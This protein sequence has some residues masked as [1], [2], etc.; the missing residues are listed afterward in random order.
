MPL[1]RRLVQLMQASAVKL[2]P[3]VEALSF[4]RL[5]SHPLVL[6]AHLQQMLVVRVVVSL[7]FAV[8][9]LVVVNAGKAMSLLGPQ[10][11]VHAPLQVQASVG[12]SKRV[13][14]EGCVARALVLPAGSRP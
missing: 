6:P 7:P 11:E 14:G 4:L 1:H 5:L 12:L 13:P 9:A 2:L 8:G 3:Q 10:L